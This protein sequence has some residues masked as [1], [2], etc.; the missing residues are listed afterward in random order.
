M[1][2]LGWNYGPL[3]TEVYN[4]D[5]PIGHSFGDVEYYR[6]QL[7]GIEGSVLEPAVGTGRVLVPL[8]ESGLR[9]EGCDTSADMLALCRAECASRDLAPVLHHADMADFLRPGAYSAVIIPAGSIVLLDGR[10]ATARALANFHQNLE[11]GG[12]LLIDV[13]APDMATD[14]APMRYWR[15]DDYVWTLQTLRVEYDRATNQRTEWLRYDKWHDGALVGSELQLFRLQLWS[16]AEFRQLL[17]DAG[18]TDV[19]VTADYG[20]AAPGPSSDNWTFRALRH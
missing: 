9:V 8:L 17:V 12:C 5:K 13:P 4:L 3:S 10:E 16:I 2:A 19:T 14:A 6:R 1:H 15:R 20:D 7:G 18:F 11:P